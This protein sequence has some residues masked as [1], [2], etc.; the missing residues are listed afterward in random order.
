MYRTADLSLPKSLC[1]HVR[2]CIITNLASSHNLQDQ[3]IS[4]DQ[5]AKAFM[6]EKQAAQRLVQTQLAAGTL[7]R[8]RAPATACWAIRRRKQA[9]MTQLV[10]LARF[11][12][13]ESPADK[14]ALLEVE[15][16][17]RVVPAWPCQDQARN[18][19][20]GT[21]SRRLMAHPREGAF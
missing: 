5:L 19:V 14:M 18:R 15:A 12:R 9:S 10:A 3:R 8:H 13:V 2:Q 11:M 20:T 21:C 6:A 4:R 17:K 16:I 1:S 7:T